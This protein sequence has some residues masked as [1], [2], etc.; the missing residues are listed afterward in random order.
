MTGYGL[1]AA[2]LTRL[3]DA[4][5]KL[6]VCVEQVAASGGYMM[7]C[8][9]DRLVASPFAVLGSIGVISEIPN[10]YERLKKEG[11]EFQTVTAGKFKRTAHAHQE[12]RP[13]GRR[14]VQ[15]G[16]RGRARAVQDLCRVAAAR[17][18]HRRRRHRRDV[19]RR[20]RPQARVVRRTENHRRRAAGHGGERARRSSRSSTSRPEAGPPRCSRGGGRRG[21]VRDRE[22]RAAGDGARSARS[23]WGWRR[24]PARRTAP[25][26]A[27]TSPGWASPAV[28][29]LGAGADGRGALAMDAARAAEKVMARDGRYAAVDEDEMY[30]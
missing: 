6:T 9:A 3:R 27:R 28:S 20:R 8:C 29:P 11:I 1:A 15:S 25:A 30:F 17:T 12:D 26:P 5:I 14:E 2:Q 16:H 19:V 4:D 23:R 21:S 18:R 10:L 7:A 22:W 13:Q 24:S